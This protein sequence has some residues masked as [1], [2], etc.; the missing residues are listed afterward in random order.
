MYD[1]VKRGF[2]HEKVYI[3][4][5]CQCNRIIRRIDCTFSLCVSKELITNKRYYRKSLI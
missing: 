1:V 4:T 2:F 5:I 3:Y